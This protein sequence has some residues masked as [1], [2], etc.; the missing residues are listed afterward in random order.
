M[1]S[2][3]VVLLTVFQ[4]IF[5]LSFRASYN[6]IQEPWKAPNWTDT[7]V[8]PYLIEPLTLPQAQEI[9]ILYCESCHG[10]QGHGDGIKNLIPGPISFKS[11]RFIKQSAGAVYWKIREGRNEMPSFKNLLSDEQNWQMVEYL[12]D[13]SKP[14][15]LQKNPLK[16]VKN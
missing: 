1:L 3:R 5:L 4:G 12:R 6:A 13:I 10:D 14:F 7:L 8:N 15:H 9:Y 2:T 11:T 16:S